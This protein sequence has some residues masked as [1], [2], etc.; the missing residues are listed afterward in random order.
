MERK[1][2]FRTVQGRQKPIYL[3]YD[4]PCFGEYKVTTKA[5]SCCSQTSHQVRNYPREVPKGGNG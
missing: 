4:K 5:C 3:V 1:K 2:D